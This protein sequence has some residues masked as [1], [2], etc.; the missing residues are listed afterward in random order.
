[1]TRPPLVIY[2]PP[3]IPKGRPPLPLDALVKDD[4]VKKARKRR[5]E[6]MA[7]LMR[8]HGIAS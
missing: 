4:P 8:K 3:L 2:E 7:Q 5:R 6:R 1:M